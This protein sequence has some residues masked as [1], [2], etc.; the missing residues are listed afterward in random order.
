MVTEWQPQMTTGWQPDGNRMATGWY[1]INNFLCFK[2]TDAFD[3]CIFKLL[4]AVLSNKPSI[5]IGKHLGK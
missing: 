2:F 1:L 3:M 4:K 5:K